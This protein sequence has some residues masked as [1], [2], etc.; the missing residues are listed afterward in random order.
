MAITMTYMSISSRCNV[1]M[2]TVHLRESTWLWPLVSEYRLFRPHKSPNFSQI[3]I[4][5]FPLSPLFACFGRGKR[6]VW[7]RCCGSR[8]WKDMREYASGE[9]DYACEWRWPIEIGFRRTS[10]VRRCL[11]RVS[12]PKSP[13]KCKWR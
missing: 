1:F 8:R 11:G 2:E 4:F 13:K 12:R 3:D 9:G 7:W 5:H 6:W 10:T